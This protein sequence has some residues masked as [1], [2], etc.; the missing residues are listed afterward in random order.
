[1]E[2]MLAKLLALAGMEFLY[3]FWTRLT[4]S[5]EAGSPDTEDQ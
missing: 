5:A 3:A 2:V 1:M 4:G